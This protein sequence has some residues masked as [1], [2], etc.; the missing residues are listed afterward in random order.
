[1]ESMNLPDKAIDE[2]REIYKKLYCKSITFEEAKEKS[3]ELLRFFQ[4]VYQPIKKDWT[5]KDIEK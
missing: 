2:Y 4:L 3:I 5:T 1:M